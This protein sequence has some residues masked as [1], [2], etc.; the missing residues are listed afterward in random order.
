[1]Y[2]EDLVSDQEV[3]TRALIDYCGLEWEDACMEFHKTE[4]GVKTAS[5]WQVRQPLYKTARARW[6]N[7]DRHLDALKQA[8]SGRG[9]GWEESCS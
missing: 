4:R 1:M 3:Q 7:Y 6:R 5:K 9:I 2:Y 8:L